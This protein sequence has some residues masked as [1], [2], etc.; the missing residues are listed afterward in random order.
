MLGKF[1]W[2]RVIAENRATIFNLVKEAVFGRKARP[3]PAE[4]EGSYPDPETAEASGD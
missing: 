4:P 2:V 1:A 3:M